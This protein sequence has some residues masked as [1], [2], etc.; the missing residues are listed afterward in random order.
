ML[1]DPS[2]RNYMFHTLRSC[3]QYRENIYYYI[4]NFGI[5]FVF[6]I[7]A[8]LALYNC[9]LNKMSD[10]EK[11]Q[12]MVQDQ[13]YVMSKI[14][15]YKQEMEDNKEMMTNITNLPALEHF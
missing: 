5:L 1:I 3:H 12:K 8:G 10:L 15:H 13:Q 14:R 11:Q 6:V 2:F 9:S 4:L 7:I